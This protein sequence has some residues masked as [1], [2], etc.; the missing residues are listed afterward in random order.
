MGVCLASP[1]AAG[2]A[3]VGG[4]G[5]E[6]SRGEREVEGCVVGWG[7]VRLCWVLGGLSLASLPF[8][9]FNFGG[10]EGSGLSGAGRP[11]ISFDFVLC[12]RAFYFSSFLFGGAEER[13]AS[14]PR[15]RSA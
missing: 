13:G 14:H 12:V 2:I 8:F 7:V 5:G 10:W 9:F 15:H 6:G 4:G 11:K 3:G 1:A